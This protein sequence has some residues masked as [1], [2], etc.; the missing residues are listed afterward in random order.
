MLVEHLDL[1]QLDLANAMAVG[2]RGS[3]EPMGQPPDASVCD[4]G[5]GAEL[6]FNSASTSTCK[7]CAAK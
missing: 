2:G 7:L 4:R 6:R 1:V 5:S 3:A